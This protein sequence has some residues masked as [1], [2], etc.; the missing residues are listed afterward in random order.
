M[1]TFWLF[2]AARIWW[3]VHGLTFWSKVWRKYRFKSNLV[4][5]VIHYIELLGQKF[6][7]SKLVRFTHSWA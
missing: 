2:C 6:P 4:A 1:H 3:N 5:Q 7:L